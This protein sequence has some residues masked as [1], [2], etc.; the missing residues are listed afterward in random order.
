M[1]VYN[2]RT[3]GYTA[4]Y[5]RDDEKAHQVPL[6]GD[7]IGSDDVVAHGDER[8]VSEERDEHEHQH[9]QL[10]EGGPRVAFCYLLFDVFSLSVL[11]K[12][13]SCLVEPAHLVQMRKRQG[14]REGGEVEKV[15]GQVPC[16]RH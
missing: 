15:M 16:S 12:W 6:L 2:V 8:S 1:R 7:R 3:E 5:R 9:R 13:V 10:E 4:H 14:G 11:P